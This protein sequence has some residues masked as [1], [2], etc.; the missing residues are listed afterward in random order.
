MAYKFIILTTAAADA[1]F[2]SADMFTVSRHPGAMAS[3]T[4]ENDE[5]PEIVL[6]DTFYILNDLPAGKNYNIY[7]IPT[8]SHFQFYLIVD[9]ST[10][11]E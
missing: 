1:L 9:A 7:G 6:S 10:V 4:F 8:D 5:E 2:G 11:A 3:L